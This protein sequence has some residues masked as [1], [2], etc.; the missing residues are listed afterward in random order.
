MSSLSPSH[1]SPP[2]SHGCDCTSLL[3]FAYFS[4][5]ERF[6]SKLFR[7]TSYAASLSWGCYAHRGFHFKG[8][9]IAGMDE[10]RRTDAVRARGLVAI[11]LELVARLQRMPLDSAVHLGVV[12]ANAK[13]STA[14][15]R[16]AAQRTQRHSRPAYEERSWG[17]CCS[18]PRP[19]DP[20]IMVRQFPS[21]VSRHEEAL[22]GQVQRNCGPGCPITR[23]ALA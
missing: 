11:S 2:T 8:S 10:V 12:E 4:L 1:P 15:G 21:A 14:G 9:G 23:A 16:F 17:K 6:M 3:R 18:L 7:T 20:A 22:R 5:L 19:E 13:R